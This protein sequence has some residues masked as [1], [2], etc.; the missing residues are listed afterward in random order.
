MPS[1]DPLNPRCAPGSI[2]SKRITAKPARESFVS[3][4]ACTEPI[5]TGIGAVCVE[6]GRP[7]WPIT[8]LIH[9]NGPWYRIM[10]FSYFNFWHPML[11][12]PVMKRLSCPKA[13]NGLGRFSPSALT[14]Y[15]TKKSVHEITTS[16][17]QSCDENETLPCPVIWSGNRH[18]T[19]TTVRC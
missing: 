13:N 8:M 5:R 4:C 15:N 2:N 9:T 14:H 6:Y 3:I 7:K 18:A 19:L 1:L 10:F 12:R 16:S 11:V 17:S